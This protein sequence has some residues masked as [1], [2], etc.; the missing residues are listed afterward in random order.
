MT[1]GSMLAQPARARAPT[2]FE[3]EQRRETGEDDERLLRV[4]RAEPR[5]HQQAAV[6]IAPMI[7]PTVLAA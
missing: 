4:L 6:P 7:A 2:R 1:I 3:D 5:D